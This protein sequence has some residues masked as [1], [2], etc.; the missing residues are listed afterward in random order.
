MINGEKKS[1]VLFSNENEKFIWQIIISAIIIDLPIIL[2]TTTSEKITWI[3][4]YLLTIFILALLFSIIKII[5]EK[6]SQQV[7]LQQ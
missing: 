7:I 6:T 4:I 5:R 1:W 2:I 3:V